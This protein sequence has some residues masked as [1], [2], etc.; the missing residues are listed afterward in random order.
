MD[1]RKKV[2]DTAKTVIPIEQKGQAVE[3]RRQG[4][5]YREIAEI[6]GLN[7]STINTKIRDW[8]K[9]LSEPEEIVTEEPD[10]C[11][12]AVLLMAQ[13]WTAANTARETKLSV[14][15]IRQHWREWAT[16]LGIPIPERVEHPK[17]KPGEVITYRLAD[18]PPVEQPTSEAPQSTQEEVKNLE[19][20]GPGNVDHIRHWTECMRELD[21]L[22]AKF[23]TPEHYIDHLDFKIDESNGISLDYEVEGTVSFRYTRTF[24]PIGQQ[25]A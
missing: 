24:P 10:L 17:P 1:A 20:A 25:E 16:K 18:K 3:L 7:Q 15:D 5:N 19:Q 22:T 9:K 2:F 4:K 6:T 13:G 8:Q 23:W 21:E 14:A 12:R 11:R